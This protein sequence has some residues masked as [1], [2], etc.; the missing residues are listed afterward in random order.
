MEIQGQVA[1]QPNPVCYVLR[2]NKENTHKTQQTHTKRC[3]T[4]TRM[5]VVVYWWIISVFWIIS[6]LQ[7]L[8]QFL[9]YNPKL[10]ELLLFTYLLTVRNRLQLSRR[11]RF[12][13]ALCVK[14]REIT[15]AKGFLAIKCMSFCAE[16]KINCYIEKK[17]HLS[18]IPSIF[19]PNF[20]L[21]LPH[22]FSATRD[23]TTKSLSL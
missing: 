22:D 20:P 12:R 9:H 5:V 15:I 17:P 19:P 21:N 4:T 10:F 6:L 2:K 11:L 23:V 1:H 7:P 14:S 3:S 18:L 13:L 16:M 8:S